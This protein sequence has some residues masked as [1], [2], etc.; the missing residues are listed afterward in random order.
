[1]RNPRLQQIV[2]LLFLHV[3]IVPDGTSRERARDDLRRLGVSMRHVME[4]LPDY[5]AVR[6]SSGFLMSLFDK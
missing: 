2:T 4:Y 5:D 3:R 1:M 6:S